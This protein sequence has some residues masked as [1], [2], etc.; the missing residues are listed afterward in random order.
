MIL[1]KYSVI[2]PYVVNPF[3][4]DVNNDKKLDLDELK[5]MMEKLQA[6]QTHLSLKEMIKQV[7]EDQ[8]NKINFKEVYASIHTN[9]QLNV[10]KRKQIKANL[11]VLVSDHLP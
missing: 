1:F 11:R 4:F 9:S 3:R 6:P 5:T 8:D 7:D 10:S 2:K